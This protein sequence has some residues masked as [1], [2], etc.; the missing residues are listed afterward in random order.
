MGI[1]VLG[2]NEHDLLGSIPPQGFDLFV[3]TTCSR[4][5]YCLTC[6][7]RWSSVLWTNG[8][9]TF[10]CPCNRGKCVLSKDQSTSL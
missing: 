7:T 9:E 10:S 8:G 1:S 6:C 3:I 2:G 4:W 5:C